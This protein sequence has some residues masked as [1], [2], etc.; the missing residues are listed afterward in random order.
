MKR[1]Q[2][3]LLILFLCL[4]FAVYGQFD[5][6]LEQPGNSLQARPLPN[7]LDS[8]DI[9]SAK[10]D[11]NPNDTT[12][13]VALIHHYSAI[14]GQQGRILELARRLCDIT[15]GNAPYYYIYGL[16]A[17]GG[18]YFATMQA[19]ST[20]YYFNKS[21]E[22]ATEIGDTAGII[23]AYNG[24]AGIALQ[25]EMDYYKA[26]R[27]LLEAVKQADD[28]S[29]PL[30]MS[31]MCNIA[32]I[33]YLHKDPAGLSYALEA[34]GQGHSQRNSYMIYEGANAAAGLYYLIGDYANALDY[35]REAID[36]VDIYGQHT[37]LYSLYADIQLAMGNEEEAV[38]YYDMAFEHI[39]QADGTYIIDVHLGYSRYLMS[40]GRYR[41]AIAYLEKGIDYSYMKRNAVHRYLLY[42]ELSKCYE[43]LGDTGKSLE[44]YKE[45]H[46]KAD[47][48]FNIDKER[49]LAEL[50]VRYE[51]EKK[52][53]EIQ[54]A[55]LRLLRIS[56]RSQ[57]IVLIAVI[58]LLALGA[59]WT[60]YRRQNKLYKQIVRQQHDYVTKGRVFEDAGK[61]VETALLTDKYSASSLS[62]EKGRA[63][64]ARLEEA[65]KSEKLYRDKDLTI[66]KLAEQLSTNRTYLS[67]IINEYTGASFNHYINSYR[68][69]ESIR[70]LSDPD[71]DI[72]LKVL[73]YE[74][75]FN[76]RETFYKS[77]QKAVGMSPSKYREQISK[78]YGKK[79]DN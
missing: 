58:I 36:F 48:V 66:E 53:L 47:S 74:L 26:Q 11:A 71:A 54:T 1:P 70:I 64:F 69:E 43:R 6:T 23:T 18:V 9:L 51:T 32:M 15:E 10:I 68:I 13:I 19:D 16:Q 46:S 67:Q 59:T 30:L 73:A 56:K 20:A 44:Y 75:G 25:F 14:G 27:Y 49:N 76:Y 62:D 29:D 8:I 37:G 3:C 12:S 21:L 5:P 33:Y 52:N 38:K 61:P 42:E 57:I 7:P 77:F 22:L 24:L 55:E 40:K 2:I 41:E 17:I 34:Y 79:I 35:I 4:P 60:L 72:Q 28:K 50:R 63:M 78:M 65:M 45:Y 39:G 31:V